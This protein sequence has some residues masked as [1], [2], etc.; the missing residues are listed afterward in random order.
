M[1]DSATPYPIHALLSHE[2]NLMYRIPPYQREYSSRPKS[3]HQGLCYPVPSVG[4][5]FHPTLTDV[6]VGL[7]ARQ[8]FR[9]R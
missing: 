7:T 9:M 3:D 4:T 2:S 1:I 8:R 6:E 5:E